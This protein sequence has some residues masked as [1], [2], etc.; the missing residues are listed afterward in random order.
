[1]DSPSGVRTSIEY[2]EY[3]DPWRDDMST[4]T[5]R[6]FLAGAGATAATLGLIGP[7]PRTSAQGAT[8]VKFTLPWVPE[9]TGIP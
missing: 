6:A 5:R 7:V 4:T 1:M 2:G 8:K 9:G 3:S